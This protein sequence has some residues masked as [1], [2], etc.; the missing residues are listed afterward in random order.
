MSRYTP[1][2]VFFVLL[3]L[4][5]AMAGTLSVLMLRQPAADAKAPAS[6]FTREDNLDRSGNDL[7][8]VL[9]APEA[10]VEACEKLCADLEGCRAFTFVKRSTTVPKPICW[11]KD[12]VPTGYASEC[13]TS[14][15][16]R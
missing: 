7:K 16:R 2:R 3:T 15:V 6:T 1:R 14:G 11:L 12:T 4:C 10:N 8:K 13:C 5:L 9:L